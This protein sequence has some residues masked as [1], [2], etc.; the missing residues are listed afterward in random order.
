MGG[1]EC[2]LDLETGI[3]GCGNGNESVGEAGWLRACRRHVGVGC[4]GG[5]VADIGR[6]HSE[7]EECE[8]RCK[9]GHDD[10]RL[11]S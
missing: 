10:E 3:K 4:A 2:R 5:S 11:Y 8:S 9:A 6:G 7:E 1:C